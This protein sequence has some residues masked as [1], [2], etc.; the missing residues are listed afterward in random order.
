[1]LT[2]KGSVVKAPLA[3]P[4]MLGHAP[5]HHAMVEAVK[6]EL[7]AVS[8]RLGAQLKDSTDSAA[9]RE[10]SFQS[11]LLARSEISKA[12]DF[13]QSAAK[14]D[15]DADWTLNDALADDGDL[16]TLKEASSM[17]SASLR[18]RDMAEAGLAALR[19]ERS[20]LLE[21]LNQ[22]AAE[23]SDCAAQQDE[24]L[25]EQTAKEREME[26]E[27]KAMEKETQDLRTELI[28]R[29]RRLEARSTMNHFFN[30]HKR[31]M[32]SRQAK[33]AQEAEGAKL[34]LQL[35]HVTDAHLAKV[36]SERQNILDQ[37]DEFKAKH[38]ERWRELQ[39]QYE[40]RQSKHS[41]E[42]QELRQEIADIEKG[43][44]AKWAEGEKQT[45][46]LM[47]DQQWKAEQAMSKLEAELEAQSDLLRSD[48]ARARE[49]LENHYHNLEEVGDTLES[50]MKAELDRKKQAIFVNSDAERQRFLEARLR[51]E[52]AADGLRGEAQMFDQGIR[53]LQ[54]AYASKA[55]T[56]RPP[57]PH[58]GPARPS[59]Y[60][61]VPFE[62]RSTTPA[63]QWE[64]S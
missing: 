9:P 42:V 32:A 28:R 64:A 61:V 50:E 6:R 21:R 56:P 1:M 62:V 4:P 8:E 7:A 57:P 29:I 46:Q 17:R 3:V 10:N 12:L 16:E 34:I 24:A 43:F 54:E 14:M 18:D 52:R 23:L 30:V 55:R 60:S 33:A 58:S 39:A 38:A 31:G 35:K 47:K 48:V 45:K 27:C 15:L 2:K 19:T 5:D 20:E 11:M 22:M 13:V 59:P 40:D 37:Q 26:R 25:Q 53:F 63:S 51:N 49:E 41:N 44:K 36:E